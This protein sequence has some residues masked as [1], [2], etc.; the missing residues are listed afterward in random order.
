MKTT[1]CIFDF[2]NTLIKTPEP[3]DGK[4]IWEEKTNSKWPHIGWW[5]KIESLSIDVFDLKPL[6]NVLTAYNYYSLFDD[7]L[8]VMLTG[9]RANK[10]NGVDMEGAVKNVLNKYN[11]K[12]DKYLFNY[13][14]ETSDNKIEQITNLLIEYDTIRNVVMFDDRDEHMPKFREFGVNLINKRRINNFKLIHVKPLK[15][16]RLL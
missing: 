15:L 14:G 16:I 7:N 12:F 6:E 8:M 9:R 10:P 3:L 1:L 11:L 4:P 5:S 2:D 13:G